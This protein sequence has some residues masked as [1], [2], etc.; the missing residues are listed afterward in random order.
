V[1]QKSGTFSWLHAVQFLDGKN[2]WA[3][4]ANGT[5]LKTDDGGATW[6]PLRKPTEDSIRDIHFEDRMNGWLLCQRDKFKLVTNDESGSYLL[7]TTDGG[8]GWRRIDIAGNEGHAELVRLTFTKNGAAWLIGEAGTLLKS[9]DRGENWRRQPVVTRYLLLSADFVSDRQGWLAGAGDTI[10]R[11][12]DGGAT[13][14]SAAIKNGTGHTRLNAV[15][16][17]DEKFGWAVGAG[18]HIFAT[19][20]GGASWMEQV[21]NVD[22]DLR[23]V[24][25]IDASEGWC[26]GVD[27]TLLHTRDG[28]TH[29][30]IEPTGTHH[31]LEQISIAGTGRVWVVGFGGTILALTDTNGSPKLR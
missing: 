26:A 22:V 11:T 30:Q 19:I 4:G 15:A 14:K 23:D 27:G 1:G 21:S 29:W 16:F 18:G 3:G 5:L 9:D 28:G 31:P 17:A 12:A 24:K 7:R 20:D 25:F 13:W 6:R 10:I 8:D 2:G